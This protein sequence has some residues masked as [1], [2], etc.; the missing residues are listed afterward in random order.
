MGN[1]Q[2]TGLHSSSN[3]EA[4]HKTIIPDVEGALHLHDARA[5][6]HKSR[7]G[8]NTAWHKAAKA[9]DLLE[10]KAM[11]H[12]T[13]R[14]FDS[15][16]DHIDRSAAQLVKLGATAQGITERLVN[17]ANIKGLT[18]LML[19]CRHGWSHVAEFLLAHGE[20]PW[21]RWDLCRQCI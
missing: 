14:H 15:A 6:T 18:P 1:I 17:Q 13:A 21:W 2:V 8:G 7:S 12:S 10:L 11:V 19:A 5:L 9:G 4:A 16:Q 3:I 20:T